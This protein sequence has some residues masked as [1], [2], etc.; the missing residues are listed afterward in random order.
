MES[1]AAPRHPM[2]VEEYRRLPDGDGFREELVR[3]R[4]VREPWPAPLHG[5]LQVRLA[6]LLNAHVE[7]GDLGVV[8]SDV[9]FVLARDPDTVRAPDLAFVARARV[10]RDPYAGGFWE[11]APDL[12]VEIVSPSNRAGEVQGRILDYLDAGAREVWVVDPGSRTVAIHRAGGQARL[13][14]DADEISGSGEL[15]GFGIPLP[16]LFNL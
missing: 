4:L 1:A 15:A 9:G 2:T 13:L 11:M 14:R 8:L 6:H 16:R 12:A 3:G 7:A 5:R 10:P